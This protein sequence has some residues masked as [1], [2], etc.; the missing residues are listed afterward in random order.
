MLR[1]PPSVATSLAVDRLS[2]TVVEDRGDHLVVRTPHRPEYHWGNA[3]HVTGGDPDDAEH[4]LGVFSREFPGADYRA[5]GM[6]RLPESAGWACRGL[7]IEAEE[8][9]VTRRAPVSTA[10]PAGYAVRPLVSASDWAARRDAEVTENTRTGEYPPGQWPVFVDADIAAN[11]ALADDGRA[12]WF[13]AFA[14][15]GALAAS[16]GIVALGTQAR[17]QYVLTD[18][19]HRRRGLARHLLSVAAEW[20]VAR[21][22]Q[23]IVIVAE[24]QS[25]AARLYARAGFTPGETAYAAYAPTFPV[26]NPR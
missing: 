17:Y 18:A 22:A 8:S 12:A 2:G 9:L 5:I 7:H 3:V 11:R 23:E 13:G 1:L 6:P 19:R 25:D 16:L 10:V 26:A 4:W 21:G 24:S 20:A 14:A 15:D